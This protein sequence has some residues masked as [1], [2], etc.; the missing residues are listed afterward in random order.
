MT[1]AIGTRLGRLQLLTRILTR[2]RLRMGR[3][4]LRMSQA[5]SREPSI[6]TP[7]PRPLLLVDVDGVISLF[8]FPAHRRPSG[9]WLMV[10]GIS[11]LL[12]AEAGGHLRAL[13]DRFE[14]VWCTGWEEKANEYLPLALGLPAPLPHLAF[15]AGPER[16][17]AHWKLDA[18]EAHAGDRPL[19][20]VDD[21]HGGGCSAWA[22]ARPA[23]TLLV[24][25]RP[26][27]GLT[28]DETVRLIAWADA[29]GASDA[30]PSA[31]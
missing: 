2:Y 21:D 3:V 5:G 12:S 20:W 10:D 22:A 30:G 24:T 13:R 9:T 25:T 14:L 18:I 15:D 8:G 31:G 6:S 4:T 26:E 28:A 1:I 16:R 19:A 17:H 23:P 11:H 29:L 7:G 27:R